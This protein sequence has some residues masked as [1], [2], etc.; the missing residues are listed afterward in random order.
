MPGFRFGLAD[1]LLTT[2]AVGIW[3]TVIAN[4]AGHV[5]S[6]SAVTLILAG[7]TIA[8]HYLL[9]GYRYAWPCAAILAPLIASLCLLV[10]YLW[11]S[12]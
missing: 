4:V 11:V 3:L 6:R 10:V 9:R 7:I 1:V 2:T 5:L 8:V 12:V